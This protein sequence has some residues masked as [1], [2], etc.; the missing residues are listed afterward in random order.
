MPLTA[1]GHRKVAFL[2]LPASGPVVDKRLF[3]TYK[4]LKR[5]LCVSMKC[6]CQGAVWSQELEQEREEN[7]LSPL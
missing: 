5:P 4:G 3:S 6:R 2:C 7:Q 1:Q